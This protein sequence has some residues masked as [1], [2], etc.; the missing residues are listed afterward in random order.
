[1]FVN[2]LVRYYSNFIFDIHRTSLYKI[3]PLSFIEALY[4]LTC[5]NKTYIIISKLKLIFWERKGI[6]M[7]D[8]LND[9]N[10]E[11]KEL[12]VKSNME[13]LIQLLDN[14]SDE[15][16]KEI[17]FFNYEVIKKYY[18]T[19]KYNVLLQYVKFVAY[20]SYLCEY[21]LKRKLI[22]D[23]NILD[24]FEKIL[25]LIKQTHNQNE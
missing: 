7:T 19:E 25:N 13:E 5:I 21:A 4:K 23:D 17:T 9:L 18:D 1:M 14:E 12:F 2:T 6:I 16:V 24:L 8:E 10:T 11:L 20:T 15:T 22:E 3:T